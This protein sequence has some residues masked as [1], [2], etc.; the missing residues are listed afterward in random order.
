MLHSEFWGCS[1]AK[2]CPLATPLSRDIPR[3]LKLLFTWMDDYYATGY[4]IGSTAQRRLCLGYCTKL[5]SRTNRACL[6]FFT[7]F[8]LL[9]WTRTKDV[10]ALLFLGLNPY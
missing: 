1:D 8:F 7:A 9:S 5:N 4:V 6:R 2:T 10:T 3:S